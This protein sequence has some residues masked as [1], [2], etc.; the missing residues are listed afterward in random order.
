MAGR[1][2]SQGETTS[3][4]L[5]FEYGGGDT[6]VRARVVGSFEVRPSLR[7]LMVASENNKTETDNMKYMVHVVRQQAKCVRSEY[8]VVRTFSEFHALDAA[9]R[10]RPES[11]SA[12]FP[13]FPATVRQTVLGPEPV[14]ISERGFPTMRRHPWADA[15]LSA[16][17][18]SRAKVLVRS[19]AAPEGPCEGR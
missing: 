18:R 14:K 17:D 11:K 2:S 13:T 4:T 10:R 7:D 3:G 12:E 5:N 8:K 6:I 16:L 1:P 19:P 15:E 9:L